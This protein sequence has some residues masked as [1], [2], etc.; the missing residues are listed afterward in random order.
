MSSPVLEMRRIRKTYSGVTVLRDVDLTLEEGQI[1][2]I[3]E[4]AFIYAEGMGMGPEAQAK[5]IEQAKEQLET[6]A[7]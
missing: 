6:L 2:G 3:N 1:I 7:Y 5:G 4:V